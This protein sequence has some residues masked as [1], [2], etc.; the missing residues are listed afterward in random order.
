MDGDRGGGLCGIDHLILDS[1]S[2]YSKVP[3]LP[4]VVKQEGICPSQMKGQKTRLL[5]SLPQWG[6]STQ[7]WPCSEEGLWGS[8][9]LTECWSLAPEEALPITLSWSWGAGWATGSPRIEL[10]SPVPKWTMEE[11]GTDP[12]PTQ[13][14][15][16]RERTKD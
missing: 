10:G 2:S 1:K 7:D 13:L 6:R 12:V 16:T 8:L 11:R 4:C 15:C 3:V 9:V 14:L 5:S